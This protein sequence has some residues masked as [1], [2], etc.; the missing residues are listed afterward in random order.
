MTD[1]T[2]LDKL[3]AFVPILRDQNSPC[4]E[5]IPLRGKGTSEEPYVM[6]TGGPVLTEPGMRFRQM[7]TD[8]GWVM[9]DF[10]WPQWAQSKDAELLFTN[11]SALSRSSEEQLA[12]ILTVLI[13]QDR[14][15]EGELAGA[16]QSGLIL[17]VA[18]RAEALASGA[19]HPKTIDPMA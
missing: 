8:A 15:I 9:K 2:R 4:V 5:L 16:F 3:A 17:A 13:R 18:E 11:R 14:F 10:D 6:G 7:A 12:K 19:P 1:K